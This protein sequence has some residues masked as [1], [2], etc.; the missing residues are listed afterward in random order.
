MK[1]TITKIF[2][3]ILAAAMCASF[4]GCGQSEAQNDISD[5]GGNAAEN[6]GGSDTP[7]DDEGQG[8]EEND[9]A[10]DNEEDTAEPETDADDEAEGEEEDDITEK[11]KETE[12]A[13][14][15]AEEEQTAVTDKGDAIAKTA[16]TTVGYDFLFGGESPEEGGFDNSGVMYYALTE[17]GISCPRMLK[18]IIEIGVS[19]EYDELRRGDLVF[20]KM[21]DGSDIVFGG[22]YVGEGKAVMSFSE[23]IPVKI[24]DVTTNYYRSTFV[25]GVRVTG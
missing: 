5:K 15:P 14:I 12:T 22:V 7:E 2:A 11:D 23:G 8:S 19:V 9:G 25:K 16:E 24:V 4:A 21:D 18:D 17:N 10:E 20:F 6:N 3:I 1:T 13:V